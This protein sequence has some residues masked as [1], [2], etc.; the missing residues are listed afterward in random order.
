M[1]SGRAGTGHLG[2]GRGLIWPLNPDETLNPGAFEDPWPSIALSARR[3]DTI[4][5]DATL[6]SL[7][8]V[9]QR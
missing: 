1:R 5:G 8:T 7:S 3:D 4:T 9:P 6:G 2:S